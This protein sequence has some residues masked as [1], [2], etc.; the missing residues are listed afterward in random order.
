MRGLD[1][2]PPP[3]FG[4][5]GL[6]SGLEHWTQVSCWCTDLCGTP[7]CNGMSQP[8]PY[9]GMTWEGG[10]NNGALGVYGI[11]ERSSVLFPFVDDN[12]LRLGC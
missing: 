7:T 9:K 10:E 1:Y 8:S 3:F 6:V 12:L 5:G 11:W 4:G 2:V